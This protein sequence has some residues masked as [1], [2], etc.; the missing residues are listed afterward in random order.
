MRENRRQIGTAYERVAAE[1]LEGLGYEILEYN[2]RNR[3]GEIDLIAKDEEYLCFVEVKYRSDG[4]C[5]TGLEAVNYRKQKN[6]IRV[7]QFYLMKQG[8]SEWTPCRFD[9]VSIDGE[10]ITLVKNAFE[11]K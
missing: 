7:A 6:I 1:Y 9:V 3:I 10:D 8:L 4:S 11:V 2:Y 5:G